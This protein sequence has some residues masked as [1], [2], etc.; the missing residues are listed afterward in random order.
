VTGG[1]GFIGSNI[2]HRCVGLGARVSIM[3]NLEPHCGGNLHNL[4]GIENAVQL[5]RKDVLNLEALHEAVQ[6]KDIIFHC[7]ALTSHGFS[8]REPLTSMDAN[9]R[10]TMNLLEAIRRINSGCRLIHLGTSTQIGALR[11]RPAT[12]E[13]PEFPTDIYSASKSASE[14]AVLIYARAYGLA[15]TV[16]RLSNVYG[17]RASIHSPDFTFNNYFIGLALRDMDVTVFG[18]GKQLRNVL[19]VDDAVDVLVSSALSRDANAEVYLAAG[20]EHLTVAQIA[21]ETVRVVGKGRVSYVPWPA[22]RK[23][24]ELGDAVLS[25]VKVKQRFSW[26]P[27]FTLE[28]GLRRSCDFYGGC[29]QHYT[30]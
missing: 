21:E 23:L 15:T 19:F 8:M 2:A 16:I 4:S 17:P 9:V 20:D 3:D 22:E 10:C 29:L 1:L 7:A 27:R 30:R 11:F 26:V 13:H 12:E 14:K 18:T 28:E 5:L 24:V 6:G 25:N